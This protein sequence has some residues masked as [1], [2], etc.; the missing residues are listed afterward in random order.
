MVSVPIFPGARTGLACALVLLLAGCSATNKP[1]PVA[2]PPTPGAGAAP[3][4][5]APPQVEGPAP[6]GES[7]GGVEV[8][9]EPGG[10]SVFVNGRL[11][12]ATPLVLRRL[13]PGAYSLRLEKQGLQPCNRRFSVGRETL[14]IRERLAP[15]PVGRLVVEVEPR[16]AEVLLD[17][18]LVGLTPLKLNS[19]FPGVHELVIRKTNYKPFTTVLTLEPGQELRYADGSNPLLTDRILEMLGKAIRDEPQRVANYLDKAHYLF[20]NNRMQEAA[21]FFVRAGEVANEP[22]DLKPE[23]GEE[24]R[25]AEQRLRM[26][27]RKRLRQEIEKHRSHY[28][29]PDKNI[30]EF[31]EKYEQAQAQHQRQNLDSWEWVSTEAANLIEGGLH[32][33]AEQLY[34]GHLEKARDGPTAYPCALELF[35]IRLVRRNLDGASEIFGRLYG[36]AKERPD[37]VLELGQTAVRQMER[38]RTSQRDSVLEMA[39]KAFRQSY[40]TARAK[41]LKANCAFELGGVL[42]SRKHPAEAVAYFQESVAAAPSEEVREERSLQLAEALRQSERT[43]EARE[44]YTRLARSP[45]PVVRTRAEAGLILTETRRP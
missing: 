15:Q 37:R 22:L 21:E 1:A 13:L 4:A 8:S 20:V 29:W 18:E 25:A 26:T 19:V 10:A 11:V 31:V 41:D 35:K 27:D 42:I 12:G 3:A 40:E 45:R 38:V 44:I 23:L 39:E 17:G 28:L 24:E 5:P 36:W 6:A 14:V 9:S 30:R 2:V 43:A 32:E 16:G 7:G 33:R 34:V